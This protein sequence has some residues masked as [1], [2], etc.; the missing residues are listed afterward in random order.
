MKKSILILMIAM[1]GTA[2]NAQENE[3]K[4]IKEVITNFAKAA[5]ES[6]AEMLATYLDE[7]YRIV[8]NRLF[9]SE[10]VSIINKTDY[11]AK[12]ET[13]EWGGDKRTVEVHSIVINGAT[14]SAHVTLKGEK[15]TFISI[16]TLIKNAAGEWRLL[17]DTPTI[18]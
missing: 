5:D 6:N 17:S 10:T 1:L 18:A 13:K 7:N 8:M 15:S 2:T 9:G 4:S 12:I 16:F 3:E 11:L 14:A